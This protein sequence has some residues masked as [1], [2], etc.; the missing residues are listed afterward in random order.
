MHDWV[1]L[2]ATGDIVQHILANISNWV[3]GKLRLNSTT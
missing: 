1:G 2:H 3:Y